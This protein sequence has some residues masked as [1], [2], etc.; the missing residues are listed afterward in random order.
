MSGVRVELAVDDQALRRGLTDLA[1]RGKD[2]RVPLRSIGEMMLRSTDERFSKER[3]PEG[4]P[5][6]PL[7]P[8][9]LAHKRNTRILTEAGNLRGSINYR[10]SNDQL[11][12]GTPSIYG[13][14]HQLGGE[15]HQAARTQVMAV[16][17]KGRFQ[18]KKA[19][20]RARKVVQIRYANLQARTIRMPA[21]PYL[22][23]SRE[24]AEG[25]NKILV[26]HLTGE[27]L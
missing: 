26:R 21:R 19:S 9:T 14:I 8:A 10:V 18:S 23:F 4:Q 6:A 25:A 1:A 20:G 16:N 2:L 15:I 12:V 11:E 27:G 5:W 7:M 22:G 3:D 13:A 24:D 17:K